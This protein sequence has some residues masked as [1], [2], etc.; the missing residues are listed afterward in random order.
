LQA[1]VDGLLLE[2]GDLLGEGIDVGGRAEP[3]FAPGL[4]AERPGQVLFE[5]PDAGGEP[6]RAFMGGEQ[7]G[8]QRGAGDSRAGGAAAGGRTAWRAWILPSRSRCL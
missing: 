2:M 4:L 1:Q 8:L 5:L 3:G 6:R 7:V